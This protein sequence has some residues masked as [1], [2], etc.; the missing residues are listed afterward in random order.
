MTDETRIKEYKEEHPNEYGDVAVLDGVQ[1]KSTA[2]INKGFVEFQ[3]GSQQHQNTKYFCFKTS[4]FG[5]NDWECNI[6]EP[7]FQNRNMMFQLSGDD[8]V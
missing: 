8:K 1:M 3:R 2:E 7:E 5:L 6:V 4:G